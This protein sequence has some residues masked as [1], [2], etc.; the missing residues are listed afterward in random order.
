VTVLNGNAVAGSAAEAS[1]LLGQ[2]GYRTLV[3]PNNLPA[4][5]PSQN[6]FK[7]TI[8]F[9]PAK[10]RSA[11]AAKGL[12]NAF[13]SAV[14]VRGIPPTLRP[15]SAGAMTVVVVGKTFHGALAPAPV[16]K[17]PPKRP[18]QIRHDPRATLKMLKR[19][20]KKVPFRVEVPTVVEQSSRIAPDTPIRIY[21]MGDKHV[22][23]RL[24]F[25]MPNLMDYWGVQETNWTDAPA[26]ANPSTTRTIKGRTYEFYFS[27]PHLHMVV[28][29]EHDASYWVVNSLTDA[30]SNETMLAIAKGLRPLRRK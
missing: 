13:G 16:D 14:T 5:A 27:G 22:G 24:T 17:T 25:E 3:P 12:A 6:H 10:K 2:R 4:N 1:Y 7:T 11:A 30:L 19:A 21:G 9:D 29:R 15:L 28:L 26:L 20:R 8:Y 18:P 23:I